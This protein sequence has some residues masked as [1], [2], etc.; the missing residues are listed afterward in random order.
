MKIDINYE[1]LKQLSEEELEQLQNIIRNKIN[2]KF[3]K[4]EKHNRELSKY[5]L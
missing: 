4:I 1:E 5:I 3:E 2:D